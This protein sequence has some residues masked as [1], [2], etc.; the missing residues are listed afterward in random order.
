[1]LLDWIEGCI[2]LRWFPSFWFGL[3]GVCGSVRVG[4]VLFIA[5]PAKAG[6]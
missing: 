1:M 4:D 5:L 2:G 6:L 3:D